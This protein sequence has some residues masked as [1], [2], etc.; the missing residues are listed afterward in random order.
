[1]KIYAV[2]NKRVGAFELPTF[3]DSDLAS[4]K[5]NLQ[6]QIILDP[7]GAKKMHLDECELYC[8]GD[9]DQEKGVLRPLGNPEFLLDLGDVYERRIKDN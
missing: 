2:R 4:F 8:L 1:M 3:S 6:K 9:Y 5:F 7:E